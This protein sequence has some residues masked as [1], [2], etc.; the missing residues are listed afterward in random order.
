M[1][2]SETR[3]EKTDVVIVGAG[4]A[5]I[6]AALSVVENGGRAVVVEKQSCAGGTT[7]FV[8]GI[9]AVDSDMQ[10][11]RN[12][13]ATRDEGFKQLMEYSHWKA[14]ASLVRSVVNKS[15]ETIAWLEKM[16][17]AFVEPTADFLGGP[18][19]WHLFKGFGKDMMQV[20]VAKAE[21]KG[22]TIHYDTRATKVLRDGTGPVT[23]I[24]AVDKEGV[25]TYTQA[26]AVIIASGG[27]ADNPAWIKKYTGFDLEIDLFAVIKS[28]K[29]GEGIE[30]A[31]STGAAEEGTGVLLFN[32]GMPPRTIGPVDH[33]LG[34]VGQPT[35]WV[36]RYGVRFCDEGIIQ[37]M[38]HTGNAMARQPGRYCYRIFDEETKRQWETNGGL[39]VGNYSP[40]GLQLTDLDK[41]IAMAIEKK[42]PYV[43]AFGSIVELADRIDVDRTALCRTIDNY[44]AF[45]DKGHDDEFGKDPEFLRPVRSPKFYA[46]KCYPDFL[47]TLGGIKID[48]KMEVL[49]KNSYP[50]RGLY[51]VGC[52]AGGIYGDSYD[53]IASGI[54]SSFAL[55]SGRIA[56]ENAV[57]YVKASHG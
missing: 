27:Y 38:I 14:N 13:K 45:C 30:M 54:G 47:C 41:K 46:I 33:M 40:P 36:N 10:R 6:A 53:L 51:A 35:L 28:D 3:A 42:S 15:G 5:G 52:D 56:G 21:A 8:E 22:V 11:R 20:L 37:N 4:G 23:G 1:T 43:F 39:N 32:I 57:R 55:N 26:A 2:S 17:V 9:Y 16:G 18:R 48:E 49:D 24:I 12:V 44:N 29:T 7:N 34:A 25:K 31:W 50:I 19:V